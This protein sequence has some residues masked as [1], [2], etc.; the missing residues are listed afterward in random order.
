VT[1]RPGHVRVGYRRYDVRWDAVQALR[2]DERHGDTYSGG[3]DHTDHTIHVRPA[4]AENYKREVLLHEVLHCVVDLTGVGAVLDQADSDAHE[5]V[6]DAVA[7]AL[8][9]VLRDNPGLVAYLTAPDDEHSGGVPNSVRNF[10]GARARP[11]GP[12]CDLAA[13]H[14]GPHAGGQGL[15]REMWTYPSPPG[16]PPGR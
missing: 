9:G 12:L 7:P 3:S 8:L 16:A 6:V 13:G 5:T 10:C 15:M 14:G 1:G 4:G 11:D 2:W